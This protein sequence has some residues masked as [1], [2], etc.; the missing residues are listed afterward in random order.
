MFTYRRR[1]YYH[2]TDQMG[3]I[4]HSN[5]LKWME[6]GRIAFLDE[7]GLSYKEME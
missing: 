1:A 7:M 5:Y 2:E 4:H 3:L 6:E